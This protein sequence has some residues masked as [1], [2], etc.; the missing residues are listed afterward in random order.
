[1]TAGAAALAG[2]TMTTERIAVYLTA[3]QWERAVE[4]LDAAASELFAR[5]QPDVVAIAAEILMQ[6]KRDDD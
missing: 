1:M 4:V 3:E 2:A 6:V 5:P